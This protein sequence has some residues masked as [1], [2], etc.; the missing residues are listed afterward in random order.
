MNIILRHLLTDRMFKRQFPRGSM[1]FKKHEVCFYTFNPNVNPNEE[2]YFLT[3]WLPNF[4]KL[5]YKIYKLLIL[6]NKEQINNFNKAQLND[7]SFKCFIT[8]YLCFFSKKICVQFLILPTEKKH[9]YNAIMF[10]NSIKYKEFCAEE[11][12]AFLNQ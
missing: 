2:Y 7:K 3:D 12:K 8:N 10:I 4:K 6:E 9:K 1:F 5:L 11:I